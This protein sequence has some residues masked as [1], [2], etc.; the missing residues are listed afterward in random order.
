[1]FP[2]VPGEKQMKDTRNDE[3]TADPLDGL[4][5]LREDRTFVRKRTEWSSY[6]EE[7]LRA[8]REHWIRAADAE[9]LEHR[10]DN[11]GRR[12]AN[13]WLLEQPL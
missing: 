8:Y 4:A 13:L 9:P 10:K 5:L 2:V 3:S 12:A 1:M 7:R 11:A 6:R